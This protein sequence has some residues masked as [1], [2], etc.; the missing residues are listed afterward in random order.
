MKRSDLKSHSMRAWEMGGAPGKAGLRR[1]WRPRPLPGPG[2][3]LVRVAATA[4][5]GR[6]LWLLERTDLPRRIPCSDSVG[7]IAALG[8]G[9]EG[10]AIGERVTVNHYPDWIAGDWDPAYRRR[11]LGNNADGFLADYAR[12]PAS[13]V[14]RISA[15]LPDG[16]ACTLGTAGLT[17]WR[18]LAV[19]ARTGPSETVLTLGTGGFALQIA[20]WLGARVIMTSSSDARLERMRALGA[21]LTVNYRTQPKWAEEVLRQND[22]RGVD[23]VLNTVGYGEI[24]ACFVAAGDNCRVIHIGA[25]HATVEFHALRNFF[26]RDCSIKGVSGGSRRMLEEFLAAADVNGLTPLIAGEFDFEAVP[27][28]V[29]LMRSGS[30]AGKVVIRVNGGEA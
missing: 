13:G 24:E 8:P 28:A 25:T 14:T 9:V 1:V 10:F 12:V 16:A 26:A 11:D 18:A 22:G 3:V 20:K 21:D 30:D 27:E 29:A 23:V 17:A 19:E 6:D 4:L 5:N 7:A 2:E 15:R